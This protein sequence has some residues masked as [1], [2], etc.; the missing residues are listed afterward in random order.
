M[1]LSK[2]N[3]FLLLTLS[4][5]QGILVS[6]STTFFS[7]STSHSDHMWLDVLS[8]FTQHSCIGGEEIVIEAKKRKISITVS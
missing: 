5:N 1:P 3:Q 4:Y 8:A 7:S 2:K 6:F